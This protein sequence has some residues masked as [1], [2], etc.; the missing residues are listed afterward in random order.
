[1]FQVIRR[2]KIGPKYTF[3]SFGFYST[4]REAQLSALESAKT[5]GAYGYHVSGDSYIIKLPDHGVKIFWI[6]VR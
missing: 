3:E 6:E 2:T 1:M 5:Y 4:K